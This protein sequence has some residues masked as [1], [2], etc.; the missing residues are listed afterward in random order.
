MKIKG[1]YVNEDNYVVSIVLD[2][3]TM[4]PVQDK[5]YDKQNSKMNL[6]SLVCLRE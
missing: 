5:L 4:I 1:I 6:N 2:N 3:E